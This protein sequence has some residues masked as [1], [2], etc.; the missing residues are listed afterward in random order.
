MLRGLVQHDRADKHVGFGGFQ[1]AIVVSDF[2]PRV[3]ADI[4][5]FRV[6]ILL[7]LGVQAELDWTPAQLS[8]DAWRRRTATLLKIV[9]ICLVVVFVGLIVRR[10]LVR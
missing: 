4:V 8:T 9:N 6:G 3:G 2:E 10:V 5:C 7:A 1:L